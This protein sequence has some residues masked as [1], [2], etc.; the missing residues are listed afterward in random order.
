MSGI[1]V[2]TRLEQLLK[3]RDRIDLEI[4]AERLN[5][6]HRPAPPAPAVHDGDLS[7]E[8]RLHRLG[9]TTKQVKQ[10]AVDNGVLDHM[11]RG[12][13]NP[14]LVDTYEAAHTAQEGIAS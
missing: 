14:A 7:S 9:V 3:L 13:I 1:R 5:P 6:T 11:V 10:W 8:A 4:A 12:R 2:G